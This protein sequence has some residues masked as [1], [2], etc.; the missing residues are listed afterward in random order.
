MAIIS[1][2][3]PGSQKPV[4]SQLPSA[5]A[6]WW[7]QRI[8]DPSCACQK[9]K[10][11]WRWIGRPLSGKNC[12]Y[13]CKSPSVSGR[14]F[15]PLFGCFFGF[16]LVLK[17]FPVALTALRFF[18]IYYIFQLLQRCFVFC[19]VLFKLILLWWWVSFF[20]SAH[21][22]VHMCAERNLCFSSFQNNGDIHTTMRDSHTT[23]QR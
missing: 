8:N 3:L 20:R 5:A 9:G 16:F 18:L 11:Q 10:L 1:E 21:H 2:P 22:Y 19:W 17:S 6:N 7:T 4:A 15:T 13:F 23:W 12:L 14:I